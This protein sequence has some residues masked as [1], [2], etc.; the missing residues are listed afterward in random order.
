[1]RPGRVL[2]LEDDDAL[3]D[4]VAEV[5]VGE[6]YDVQTSR[7]FAELYRAAAELRGDLALADFWGRSRRDLTNEDHA[8]IAQ[9]TRL[10]PVVLMTTRCWADEMTAEQL[11]ARALLHK[12]FELEELL[13]TIRSALI[14]SQRRPAG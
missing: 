10:V 12:P 5:L 7:T 3:R 1:M 4:I 8:H 9:L 11:G 13:A 2:L 14:E 6:G